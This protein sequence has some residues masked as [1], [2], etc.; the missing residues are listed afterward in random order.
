MSMQQDEWLDHYPRPTTW[1]PH[2]FFNPGPILPIYPPPDELIT[3]APKLPSRSTLEDLTNF[4]QLG[5]RHSSHVV[6]ACFLRSSPPHSFPKPLS[7]SPSREER[8]KYNHDLFEGIMNARISEDEARVQYRPGQPV[9]SYRCVLW[10]CVDRLVRVGRGRGDARLILIH[11][12]GLSKEMWEPFLNFF[13]GCPQ[14]RTQVRE[15][16][17]FDAVQHGDSALVNSKAL[18][19]AGLLCWKDHSRDVVQFLTHF[20]PSPLSDVDLPTVLPTLSSSEK[21]D[22]LANGLPKNH[23]VT[24]IAH[25]W[26]GGIAAHIALLFPKLFSSL[27]L[28]DP[29]LARPH[30]P[31]LYSMLGILMKMALSRRSTWTSREEAFAQFSQSPF[32]HSW[33]PSAIQCFLNHGLYVSADGDVRLKTPPVQECIVFSDIEVAYSVWNMLPSLDKDIALRYI[34]PS[35]P[36]YGLE[37]TMIQEMVWLRP[38]NCSNI[39]MAGAGHLIP[40]EKPEEYA[41]V[42]KEFLLKHLGKPSSKM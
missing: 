33:H 11:S 7:G 10:N 13:L 17:L 41:N 35:E 12:N 36:S 15:I 39:K 30:I 23:R 27:I 26:G 22:R 37:A 38:E 2:E 34:L 1:E 25:S 31:D 42:V 9:H 19:S 18:E 8:S 16:W 29:M 28:T 6:P 20:L 40:Q 24:V 5:F 21:H 3:P 4:E 14:V 32:F